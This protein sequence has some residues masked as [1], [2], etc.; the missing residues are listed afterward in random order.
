M[1]MNHKSN[2]AVIWNENHS[3][4]KERRPRK[5]KM[6]SALAN[7]YN[8][9]G[10]APH[11]KSWLATLQ[12]LSIVLIKNSGVTLST[13]ELDN[14]NPHGPTVI[15]GGV[16]PYISHIDCDA[17]KATGLTLSILVWNRVWFS[18]ELRECMNVFNKAN[19]A[20]LR[21]VLKQN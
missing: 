4:L 12:P 15:R 9:I 3:C 2:K 1:Q 8:L 21:S 18:R 11:F 10:R 5:K 14:T 19:Q 17:T 6:K 7:K 16:L 13:L 20:W